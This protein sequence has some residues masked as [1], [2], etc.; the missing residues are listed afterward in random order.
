MEMNEFVNKRCWEIADYAYK[1]TPLYRRRLRESGIDWESVHDSKKWDMIPIINKDDVVKDTDDM[2]SEEFVAE[3]AMEQ[4]LHTHTSGSTGTFLDVYWKNEDMFHALLPLWVDRWKAAKIH[5]QDRVCLFNTTLVNGNAFEIEGNKMIVSK[6]RLSEEY[7]EQIYKTIQEFKPK[8][9]ILHPT[10]AVSLLDNIR[11]KELPMIKSVCYVELT[12]E[13]VFEGLKKEIEDS[14]DCVV[15][16]HYGTMEVQSIGY[17]EGKRYRLYDQTTYVEVLDDMGREVMEG[18]CGNIYVTSLHNHTMPFVR[19]GIGDI[20][21]IQ[22][23]KQNGKAVRFLTLKKA[24]K[25]ERITLETG[26]KISADVLLKPIEM[27]NG[28]YQHVIYQFQAVQR[29]T[30]EINIQI[31]MDEEF[32]RDKLI[33]IYNSVIRDT[34][35]G[36]MNFTFSFLNCIASKN[37]TGKLCWFESEVM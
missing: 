26:E 6:D 22:T 16:M 18:G 19:Y 13:M 4:V 37:N 7:F 1:N 20:G 21:Y 8:W 12:G 30:S 17:E 34:N 27:M 11:R 35:V 2:I 29:T 31:V 28:Y 10:I 32:G 36:S 5:S 15:K 24:R 33:N 23:E 3:V 14:F 25:N 9:M